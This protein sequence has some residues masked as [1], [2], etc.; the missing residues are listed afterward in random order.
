MTQLRIEGMNCQHCVGAVTHALSEVTGVRQVVDVDL[1]S[2]IA[3]IDGNAD[4]H[5][6]L[7]AVRD[8][9]YTAVVV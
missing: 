1:V 2:G 4:D 9:G 7:A 6:L 5:R 8:E 3:T